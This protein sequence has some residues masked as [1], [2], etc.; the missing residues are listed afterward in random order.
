MKERERDKERE[1]ENK[2]R[3]GCSMLQDKTWGYLGCVRA[4]GQPGILVECL[5]KHSPKKFLEGCF[6]NT[7][8]G[9]KN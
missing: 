6:I 4:G 2:D 9:F 3:N 8:L 1:R 7:Y 5:I